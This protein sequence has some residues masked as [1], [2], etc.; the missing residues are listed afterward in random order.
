MS[1]ERQARTRKRLAQDWRRQ[2]TAAAPR[3]L[4]PARLQELAGWEYVARVEPDLRENARLLFAGRVQFGNVSG[5]D[6]DAAKLAPVLEF[7]RAPAEGS[8]E[9]I[10][11][12]FLLYQWGVRSDGQVRAALGKTVRVEFAGT[13]ARRP[14]ALLALFDADPTRLSEDELKALRQQPPPER[15]HAHRQPVGGQLLG[16]RGRAEVRVQ[17][18]VGP[19]HLPAHRRSGGRPRRPCTGP[20]S[21]ASSFRR[22]RRTWR[23]L[24]FKGRAAS[25]GVR[26]PS[27]T[28]CMT[29]RTSRSR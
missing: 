13:E 7:G 18:A 12:E 29:L 11:H 24:R 19:Q 23:T 26:F 17:P 28:P 1:P 25:A 3:P 9:L 10:A 27:K 22:S 2:H 5:F 16:R 6:G 14:E 4:T 8:D 21:P 20:P 15:L